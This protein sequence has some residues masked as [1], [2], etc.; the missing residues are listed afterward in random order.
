MEF[1]Q[2][3]FQRTCIPPDLDTPEC[4]AAPEAATYQPQIAKRTRRAQTEQSMR[5]QREDRH[6][7]AQFSVAFAP[8]YL[9]SPSCSC[10]LCGGC[11]A[12]TAGTLATR[13]GL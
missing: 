7:L 2:I 3:T 5:G 4:C 13:R 9:V 11:A 10:R 12:S 8:R 6:W 1:A